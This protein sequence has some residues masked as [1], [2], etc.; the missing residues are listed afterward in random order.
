MN[1]RVKNFVWLIII[2]VA[3]SIFSVAR[4]G[5]STYLDF[6]EDA[7]TVSAPENYTYIV[8]YDDISGLELVDEFDPGT[9][10]SGGET[11]KYRWG[12]WKND[13]WGEYVLCSSKRIDN[14]LLVTHADGTTLALNYES[15]ETTDALLG[16][17]T[18]LIE[19]Y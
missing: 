7:L 4:G 18:N 9:M 13:A 3:F 19:K 12:N 17:I 11:R 14:A 1:E 15:E 2:I 8:N 16:L 10:I 6:G 5:T